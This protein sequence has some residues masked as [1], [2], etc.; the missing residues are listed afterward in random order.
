[1]TFS[2]SHC[3]FWQWNS[4]KAKGCQR[5]R[6]KKNPSQ[7]SR[8][9]RIYSSVG[10]Q[11][12]PLDW[13]EKRVPHVLVSLAVLEHRTGHEQHINDWR[14][15]PPNEMDRMTGR[16]VKQMEHGKYLKCPWAQISTHSL[17]NGCGLRGH[18]YIGNHVFYLW[19]SC[20][21]PNYPNL[22]HFSIET[23]GFGDPPFSEIPRKSVFNFL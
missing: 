14:V 15:H 7:L 9:L 13:I 18:F 1:M 5:Q 20:G 3:V 8:H 21:T 17:I 2:C 22:E 23:H 16:M 12:E 11:I 4:S 19:K 10:T 6:T